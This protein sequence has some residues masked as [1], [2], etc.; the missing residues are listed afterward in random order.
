MDT[1]LVGGL[2]KHVFS[3]AT[4]AAPVSVCSILPTSSMAHGRGRGR[5]RGRGDGPSGSASHG[6]VPYSLSL[7]SGRTILPASSAVSTTP[8]SSIDSVLPSQSQQVADLSMDDFLRMIR[9]V[10]QESRVPGPSVS[11]SSEPRTSVTSSSLPIPPVITRP[12]SQLMSQQ[13]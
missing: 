2:S 1:P 9:A 10:V 8:A 3:E 4:I 12:G 7:C 13:G 6:P 5:G 11:S